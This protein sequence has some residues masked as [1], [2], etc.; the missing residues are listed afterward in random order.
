ML[1]DQIS[2]YT[3]YRLR[4]KP[5]DISYYSIVI[6]KG[7]G[8][9]LNLDAKGMNIFMETNQLLAMLHNGKSDATTLNEVIEDNV[10]K[11]LKKV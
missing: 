9:N 11:L 4:D 3:L 1:D 10:K 7:V 6:S 2:S 5:I 8:I